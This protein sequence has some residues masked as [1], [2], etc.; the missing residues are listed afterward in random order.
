MKDFTKHNQFPRLTF[1]KLL[2]KLYSHY[3]PFPVPCS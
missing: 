3:Y 2:S 1:T